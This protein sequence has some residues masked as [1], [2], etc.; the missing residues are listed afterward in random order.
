MIMAT[1]PRLSGHRRG[2]NVGSAR[3]RTWAFVA[4]LL[5]LTFIAG[6]RFSAPPDRHA[7]K[8]VAT[9]GGT[10]K[11]QTLVV[12]IFSKTDTEYESNLMFFLKHGV[13]E[14]DGCYY[15]FIMQTIE[16]VQLPDISNKIPSNAEVITHPNSCY[17]WGTI[18]WLLESGRVD[19]L[20]YK[21]FLFMNSSVRGPFIP[22]FSQDSKR[23]HEHITS[24]INGT[25]KLVGPTISCEGSPKEG[26]VDGEWRT[27]PHVQ[28]YVLATDQ[29]GLQLWK[30]DGK[31]FTC[32]TSMWDVIFYG[33]LGSSLA[34]LKAGYNLESFMSRYRGV[35]W[36]QES[37]WECNSRV[38]P[39][40]EMYYDGISLSPYEVMF[41]KVK[42]VL[43]ANDWSYS[44]YGVKYGQWMDEQM[45]KGEA[46]VTSNVWKTNPA[47]LKA[48]KI[49]YSRSRGAHCFDVKY[50]TTK[51]VDL[52]HLTDLADIWE[53]YVMLGQFEGRPFQFNCSAGR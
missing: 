52:K 30:A 15:V 34:I 32:Y 22:T 28:S 46:D 37:N 20:K 26:K 35:D 5:I 1:G 21:Y 49:A 2:A 17:D 31:V 43:L 29:V 18:G 25:V 8:G 11:P 12:Y 19:T 36:R 48:P 6:T 7:A 24:R 4:S 47:P 27:N 45:D 44:R 42:G 23:W 3:L 10:A 51:N 9:Y 40:G 16:G 38:N 41:V 33:E 39:Y 13:A 14:N 53:H 50:Y